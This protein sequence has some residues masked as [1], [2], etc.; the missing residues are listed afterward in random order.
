MRE[1]EKKTVNS[2]RGLGSGGGCRTTDPPT[3]T[4]TRGFSFFSF[5]F[6]VP[7]PETNRTSLQSAGAPSSYPLLVQL[8]QLLGDLWRVECQP[9]AVSVQLRHQ[10]LQHLLERQTPS[11]A[12]L[13]GGRHGVFQDGASQSIELS[14]E[15]EKR[16]YI[17]T[18]NLNYIKKMKSI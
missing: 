1:I 8:H 4:L 5:Y 2:I 16:N 6:L 7:S 10:V 11:Q 15:K 18:V 14:T 13:G 9:Q 3:V 12:V 17:L